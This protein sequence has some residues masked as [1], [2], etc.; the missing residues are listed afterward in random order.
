MGMKNI[1]VRLYRIHLYDGPIAVLLVDRANNS[2]YDGGSVTD[3]AL[4][5]RLASNRAGRRDVALRITRRL[6][7]G[8][9]EATFDEWWPTFGDA[10]DHWAGSSTRSPVRR[11]KWRC[12]NVFCEFIHDVKIGARR[13]ET[14]PLKC[15]QCGR[16]QRVMLGLNG[17]PPQVSTD[18]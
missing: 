13:R 17:A 1:G 18:A 14:A 2:H 5:E 16:T 7:D 9:A 10:I 8:H 4:A 15:Q 11:V 12:M 6:S 3:G